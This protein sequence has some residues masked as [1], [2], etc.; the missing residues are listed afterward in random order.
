MKAVPCT[1]TLDDFGSFDLHTL[2]INDGVLICVPS[3]HG[4]PLRRKV[5]ARAIAMLLQLMRRADIGCQ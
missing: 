3:H 4:A 2:S 5:L 1:L